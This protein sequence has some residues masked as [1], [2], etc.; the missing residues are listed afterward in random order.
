MVGTLK[1]T[2]VFKEVE[3]S[4]VQ[5]TIAEL[6]GVITAGSSRVEAEA[7]LIDAL[8]EYLR[9]LTDSTLTRD[10]K[11]GSDRASLEVVIAVA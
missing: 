4:W 5:A 1:L 7:L 11:R 3:G 2:A 6:P 8:T 9:S 10:I